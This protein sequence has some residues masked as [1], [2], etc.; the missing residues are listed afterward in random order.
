LTGSGLNCTVKSRTCAVAV[1]N[2]HSTAD[3]DG[4]PGAG[5]IDTALEEGIRI[6][7][8]IGTA[9]AVVLDWIDLA[10]NVV[11][12]PVR[13]SAARKSDVKA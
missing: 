4:V 11:C 6:V 10:V 3:I 2:A 7:L 1:V 9:E 12:K 13:S 8:K 5:V